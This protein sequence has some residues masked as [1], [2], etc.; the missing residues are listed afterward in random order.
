MHDDEEKGT[1]TT[2]VDEQ[3]PDTEL[4]SRDSTTK[5]RHAS[6]APPT[7]AG[8][9]LTP[10]EGSNLLLLS[11]SR[12]PEHPEDPLCRSLPSKFSSTLIAALLVMIEALPL[13]LYLFGYS[14]GPFFVAPLSETYGRRPLF[15]AGLV[16]FTI[17][18][19][20][21]GASPNYGALLAFRFLSGVSGAVPM[22]NSGAVCGDLW[23]S[24]QRGTAM[25]FYS[26]ATFAGPALGPVI[27][28]FA[29]LRFGWPWAFYIPAI[30]SGGLLIVTILALPE[31]Y[32][33]VI[34]SSIAK[35]LRAETG[36]DRI[37][38]SLELV[39][40][41]ARQKKQLARVKAEAHRLFAMP[42]VLLFTEVIIALLT[43]YMCM[44][45][46][47]IYLLFEGYPIIFSDVHHLP[48]G[49]SSLP[50]LSTFVGAILSVPLTL[51]FQKRYVQS[52]K[53]NE[54]VPT[55][56]M[57]L[58]PSQLGG[59]CIVVSFIWLG[60]TGNYRSIHW[61]VP[62]LSGIVQGIGSVLIFRSLQTYLIDAY[63]RYSASALASNVVA[64]SIS[65]AVFPLFARAMF[66]NLGVGVACSILA[67]LMACLVP[68]PFLF[69]RYGARLRRN[70]KF[71]PV[72]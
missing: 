23:D 48:P 35:R 8:L 12:S 58:P 42:F 28:S 41:Q 34:L 26:V 21:T 62:T 14:V 52:T 47:L 63:E 18:M 19:A 33:P 22:T 39:V 57:R 4:T 67:A 9:E 65:G 32:P 54:G 72:R 15:I 40:L 68:I 36:D 7:P 56:E 1:T 43:V 44:V 30:I 46:G 60:W 16:F 17:F 49:Y 25:A 61:I 50:F 11:F 53:L 3:T 13:S 70:S 2:L 5:P 37:I 59:F 38:S 66:N 6:T 69:E 10:L 64:R 27:A 29:A 24:R 51:W 20:A 55:P 45:Y 71:A 31:T